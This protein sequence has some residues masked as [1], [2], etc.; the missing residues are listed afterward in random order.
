[1]SR[2]REWILGA[3]G[4]VAI[5]VIGLLVLFDWNWLKGPI[6]SLVSGS[7]GRPFRI[8]GNLEVE[9]S[10]QPRVTVERA[11]LGN[12]PWGSDEP[13][14]KI[15]RV[16]VRLDLLKLLEG[17]IVLPEARIARPALLLETRPDGR[18]N[19]GAGGPSRSAGARS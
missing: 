13:M 10:L 1:V 2:G 16:E 18:P 9:L 7:V 6:E 15:D 8:D 12:V 4:A 5:L 14:A 17:E 11:E 19:R 3:L